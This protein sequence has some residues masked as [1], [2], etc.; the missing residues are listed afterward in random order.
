LINLS[1]TGLTAAQSPAAFA[2]NAVVAI[3]EANFRNN[4]ASVTTKIV[5][6]D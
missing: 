4:G 2:N 6:D 1:G 3:I 5:E